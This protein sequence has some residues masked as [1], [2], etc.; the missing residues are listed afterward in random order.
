MLQLQQLGLAATV[1]NTLDNEGEP[2]GFAE[3][4]KSEAWMDSMR[5]ELSSLINNQ[6]P[7]LFLNYLLEKKQY[8]VVGYTKQRRMNTGPSTVSRVAWW[9]KVIPRNKESTIVTPSHLLETK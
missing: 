1:S 2:Q 8:A 6:K 7:G 3:A 4:S 9:Q 5:E